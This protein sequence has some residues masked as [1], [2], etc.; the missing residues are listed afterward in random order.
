[1]LSDVCIIRDIAA[2]AAVDTD[3]AAATSALRASRRA[4]SI[5]ELDKALEQ[6]GV[7]FDSWSHSGAQAALLSFLSFL[8]EQLPPRLV[9]QLLRPRH[10]PLVLQHQRPAGP[11]R[12]RHRP[13]RSDVA[14]V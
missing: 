3:S 1:M 10:P 8:Q 11:F 7:P 14:P 5:S 6:A 13:D 12:Q 4:G 9:D 2:T